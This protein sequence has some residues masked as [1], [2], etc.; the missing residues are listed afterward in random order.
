[1]RAIWTKSPDDITSDELDVLYRHLT[2]KEANYIKPHK[3]RVF[4]E[5][6]YMDLTPESFNST[7]VS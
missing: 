1:M 6:N 2:K 5:V 7:R 3:R 4:A